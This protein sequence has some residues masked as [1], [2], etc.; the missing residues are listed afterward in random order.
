MQTYTDLPPGLP[1]PPADGACDHL[2]GTRLPAVPLPSTAGGT[3]DL[4]AVPGLVVAYFYPMT[5]RPGV[6]LPAGW[7]AIP[8]ARGCTPQACG[9]RDHARELAAV[10]A[11]VFGVSTQP[12]AEQAEAAVRLHLPF[13]LLSD[14]SLELARGLRLPT[15]EADGR[16]RSKRLTLVVRDGR[17]EHV[18]YPIFPPDTHAAGV[19]E[20]LSTASGPA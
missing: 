13:V 1:V 15:F 17:I 5:G 8:G 3:I 10:G 18:F 11:T 9:F 19:V 4:A 2:P 16:P 7:D 14:E 12:P 20:W 6:P